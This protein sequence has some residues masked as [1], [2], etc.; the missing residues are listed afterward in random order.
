MPAPPA[1]VADPDTLRRWDA[2]HLWHPFS[3]PEA[4]SSDLM[5]IIVGAEGCWVVDI[6]GNRLL[7]GVSSLW[8]NLH[9]HRVPEIDAAI[10]NQLAKV[11]HSTLLGAS[12]PSAIELA[13]RLVEIAPTGLTRVFFSD[14]G[15]TAVE[16]ALKA[17][18]GVKSLIACGPGPGVAYLES[19]VR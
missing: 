11:A 16:A 14:N 13:R 6:G 4:D 15:A 17:V 9:G 1:P 2:D 12:H 5:P 7:D 18:P 19:A 8:C 10:S 3:S